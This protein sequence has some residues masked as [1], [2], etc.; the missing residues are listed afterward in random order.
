MTGPIGKASPPWHVDEDARLLDIIGRDGKPRGDA[1]WARLAQ[2]EFPGRT[3]GALRQRFL[4]LR[5]R[6]AHVAKMPFRYA[7][8]RKPK[9]PHGYTMQAPPSSL[10]EHDSLTAAFFGDPLPGR[11]A[12]DRMRGA[13]A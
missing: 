13:Q 12:L 5:K 7:S 3:Y 2:A 6:A 1:A 11:S 4:A 8:S 9:N 10:P